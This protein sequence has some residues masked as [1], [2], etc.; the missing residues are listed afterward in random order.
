MNLKEIDRIVGSIQ[1]HLFR[2]SNSF[3]VGMLKSHF[4]G[5]G[6]QFKEHQVYNPGDDVRFIDWKLSAKTN[7]TFLKT[8]EEERNV[9][10][11]ILIDLSESMLY[12]YKGTS[13]A[14][15]VL[16]IACLLFLLADKSKDKVGI[17][18]L[19]DDTPKLLPLMSGHE[20][21]ANLISQLEKMDLLN[22]KG[23]INIADYQPK[24]IDEKKTI[25]LLKS[26]IARGKEVV[27]L[28]DLTNLSASGELQKLL[29]RRNMHCFK[30]MAPLDE[31]KKNPFAVFGKKAGRG[32]LSR[33][34]S[35]PDKTKIRGRVKSI[36][37]EDRYLESFV[38][39]ML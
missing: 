38:R 5:A 4:K 35:M 22:E 29:Q 16:E 11:Y 37:V 28:S 27:L 18:L 24:L 7:T 20:G 10:I 1:S 6:L 3:S 14:Q 17:I 26:L 9:E 12:G 32:K 21:I 30:I 34:K 19:N 2:N 36:H 31:A 13:K 25:G 15:V 39:E 8:F 23:A 33:T